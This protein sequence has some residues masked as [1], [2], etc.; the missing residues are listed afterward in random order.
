MFTGNNWIDKYSHLI[1]KQILFNQLKFLVNKS[2]V[3]IRFSPD[4]KFTTQY[5]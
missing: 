1:K 5:V 4:S 3:E 2:F